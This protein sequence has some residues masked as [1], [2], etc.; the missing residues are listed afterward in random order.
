MRARNAALALGV[1]LVSASALMMELLLTRLFSVILFYHSA[2]L[3][4]A[5]AM[6]GLGGGGLLVYLNRDRFSRENL[7]AWLAQLGSGL[8]LLLPLVLFVIL[9]LNIPAR[10][11][12]GTALRL[13]LVFVLASVPFLLAGALLSLLVWQFASQIHRIYYYDLVGAALGSLAVLPVLSWVGAPNGVLVA[14]LLAALSSLL[15]GWATRAAR[16]QLWVSGAAILGLLVLLLTNLQGNLLD[17]RYAKGESTEG[18][19]YARWNAISRVCVHSGEKN[20][21]IRIDCDAAT[22]VPS[23]DFWHGDRR[24]I[25]KHFSS[26]GEDLVQIL[27]PGSRT[28]VI[29]SG[30]GRDVARAL[31]YGSPRVVAVEINPLIAHDLM[32]D[33]LREDSR[34]LFERPEVELVVDDARSAVQ[35]SSEQFEVIQATLIDT[36]ASTAAGA[37]ALTENY[38]YTVEAFEQY[39]RH[40][41]PDGIL[42]VTRWEFLPPRQA[43]R[44]VALGRAALER[45]GVANP[46]A[47]FLVIEEGSIGKSRASVLIKRSPFTEQDVARTREFLS[48][49]P[50]VRAVYVP[51]QSPP[52]EFSAM[53]SAPDLEAFAAKYPY[54]ISPTP[55]SRPFFFYTTR[56]SQ[57]LS[58]FQTNLEDMKNNVG[59]FVL[60]VAAVFGALGVVGLLLLPRFF[61]TTQKAKASR[62][63]WLYF[64][65][66]GVAYIVIEIAFIQRFIL[67]MGHPTYGIVVV[68]FSMLVGSGLGSRWSGRL[69]SPARAAIM[70]PIAVAIVVAGMYLIVLPQVLPLA[71][72]FSRMTRGLLAVALLLPIGF[73]MGIP[74]PAGVR[75]AKAEDGEALPWLWSANAG[76]S[77]FGSVLAVV[78]A[79]TIGI[80]GT[81]SIGALCYL[82]AALAA[83]LANR[84][85]RQPADAIQA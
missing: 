74:F 58:V 37:F 28:L 44:V 64:L 39:L 32:L 82:V 65:A 31:A 79:M 12:A 3:V 84:R 22:E 42:S 69:R 5:L 73:V 78:L 13:V 54:D 14:A 16:G 83:F 38:L 36:W 85:H 80:P 68:V 8:G 72:S 4:V 18:E 47:H 21:Y 33:Y 63:R 10:P 61:R 2:F 71:Q 56:W 43:I 11:G 26:R 45:M 40:L 52:N 19:L 76:G 50:A 24:E 41:T 67:F 15:L 1:G 81:A 29:G 66:I 77:V 46:A 60:M 35:R 7:P 62:Q 34:R 20:Y 9:N 23:L 17:L 75:S 27:R 59:L 25:A 51:G 55:D 49:N 48:T 70:V 6:M 30:G 53:L 57:A